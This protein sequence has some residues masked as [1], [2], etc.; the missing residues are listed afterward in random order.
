MECARC[1]FARDG[2]TDEKKCRVCG[3]SYRPSVNVYLAFTTLVYLVFVGYFKYCLTGHFFAMTGRPPLAVF[4]W[5]RFPVDIQQHPALI[6]V[7]GGLMALLV[8]VPVIVSMLH[9]KRGGILLA[10][11]ALMLGPSWLVALLLVA[12]VWI[13]GDYRL[14]LSNKIVSAVLACVPVWLFYLIGSVPSEDVALPG[15]FYLPALTAI[16]MDIALIVVL[17][18]PL[19]RLG[20]NA[21]VGGVLLF[22][23]CVI[24][25]GAYKLAIRE[26][27]VHYA[28]FSRNFGLDSTYFADLPHS[29]VKSDIEELIA[30]EAADDGEQPQD[31]TGGKDTARQQAPEAESPLQVPGLPSE[32]VDH[33]A[34]EMRLRASYE[35]TVLAEMLKR[36]KK[37]VIR[38]CAWFLD[39]YPKT[40]HRADV[41]YVQA[42]CL[43]M[44]LDTRGL[45]DE[46]ENLDDGNLTVRFDYS[47]IT[48]DESAAL[49]QTLRD[50]YADGPYAAEA[51]V[52]LAAHMARNGQFDQA[53]AAYDKFFETF[54][55][56]VAQPSLDTKDLSVFTD[57]LRVGPL[58]RDRR[59]VERI[60][61]QYYI[62]QRE[63]AFLA[64]N[65]SDG[66]AD[67]KVLGE[68][69][70]LPPVLPARRRREEL[71]ALLERSKD[72]PLADNLACEIALAEPVAFARRKMLNDVKDTYKQTD[73]AGMALM[74]LAELEAAAETNRAECLQR[75]IGY[76]DELINHYRTSY[77]SRVAEQKKRQY[78]RLLEALPGGSPAHQGD[79]G[80][81]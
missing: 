10:V 78:E 48:S 24:P 17:L 70:S 65:R 16:V 35:M 59:R 38:A 1:F 39:T 77:L 42:R 52:K 20:W 61:Q 33:K 40:T 56:V 9:G 60:E 8:L 44:V 73:G 32:K 66:G 58:L 30:R 74:A 22:L 21:R 34:R 3:R 43:D 26:D 7:L 5:A 25:I 63:R 46:N 13:A 11:I 29:S 53:M 80:A 81:P 19:K 50:D 36:Q 12:S 69:L 51:T 45:R 62:A 23:L 4:S 47:R 76:C 71:A 28:V 6:L 2:R 75:A 54:E 55:S 57:L 27:E 41:L 14:R 49:W 37:D 67:D 68:Y 79:E 18:V 15:A 31:D 64:E 72:S